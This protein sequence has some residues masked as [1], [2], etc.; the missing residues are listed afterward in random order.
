VD[1]A[2]A[3]DVK[4]EVDRLSEEAIVETIEAA[5]P[6][7]A[8]LAEEGGL[9]GGGE[10]QWIIDP[11]DGTVNYFY[12]VPY[13]CT[14][15]ACY[16]RVGE[17]DVERPGLLSAVGEPVAAVVY[18]AATDELFEAGRDTATTL[19]GRRV[20]VSEVGQLSEAM[21]C[22][23]YGSSDAGRGSLAEVT[24]RLAGR[25]RKLRCLG[26]A[27]YDLANVASGRLSA[28]YE[29]GLRIWD[30][31]AG[32]I[33]VVQAGGVFEATEYEPGRWRVLAT[34]PSLSPA[35]RDEFLGED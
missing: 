25:V 22:V 26:A 10:F 12:G 23:G 6:D 1:Q 13:W 9:R 14:S 31:A 30:I 8:I 35:L 4:L 19:N 3:Y 15:I 7:D 28:F 16:R 32:G 18:A 5:F 34:S 27:A 29:R 11:L 21:V 24:S 20:C 33:L 17:V 2:L